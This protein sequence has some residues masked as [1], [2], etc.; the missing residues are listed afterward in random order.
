MSMTKEIASN[1]YPETIYKMFFINTSAFI[2]LAIGA[3][4][5]LMPYTTQ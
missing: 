3:A 5:K 1:Y 4:T 2:N